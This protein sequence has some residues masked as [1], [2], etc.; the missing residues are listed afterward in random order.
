VPNPSQEVQAETDTLLSPQRG[1][2]HGRE[3]M[4]AHSRE[5]SSSRTRSS[6]GPLKH[7]QTHTGIIHSS[8]SASASSAPVHQLTRPI[9]PS[10]S[11][12]GILPSPG[13]VALSH[14]QSHSGIPPSL[15][16]APPRAQ[17]QFDPSSGS[18]VSST[19]THSLQ[20][21]SPVQNNPT[22]Q[23]L[24][25]TSSLGTHSTSHSQPRS[26][27]HSTTHS[28]APSLVPS[29]NHSRHNSRGHSPSHNPDLSPHD[30]PRPEPRPIST[31]DSQ[32]AGATVGLTFGFISPDDSGRPS[33]L[34]QRSE[35]VTQAPVAYHPE[36]SLPALPF[37]QQHYQSLLPSHHYIP[38]E[39]PR[40]GSTSAVPSTTSLPSQP[41]SLLVQTAYENDLRQGEWMYWNAMSPLQH[42]QPSSQPHQ[43]TDISSDQAQPSPP[44]PRKDG[45]EKKTKSQVVFGNVGLED[46]K[47]LSAP[48]TEPETAVSQKPKPFPVFSIG[49]TL[50][51]MRSD[52]RP[53]NEPKTKE[54]KERGR[55]NRIVD[56]EVPDMTDSHPGVSGGVWKFGSTDDVSSPEAT[57]GQARE[58]TQGPETVQ[59]N[60][61]NQTIVES[62][63]T[64]PIKDQLPAGQV[65][66]DF[67]PT[68]VQSSTI[69]TQYTHPEWLEV[70]DFG[71]R[72]GPGD[73]QRE[74]DRRAWD[75]RGEE[76]RLAREH[77][78]MD[79]EERDPDKDAR[80]RVSDRPVS[81]AQGGRPRRA[82]SSFVPGGGSFDRGGFNGRR[83]RGG[84]GYGRGHRY[85]R[86]SGFQSRQ[87]PFM[88]TPPTVFPP[89][90]DPGTTVFYPPP[91]PPPPMHY[92]ST[93]TNY[94]GYPQPPLPPQPQPPLPAPV[95][96]VQF[97]LDP[98][99]WQLLGQLEYYL[100]PQNMASDF[101][102][103]QRVSAFSALCPYVI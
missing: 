38:R 31:T 43:I 42:I 70:R 59:D 13:G 100:S 14:S 83:G 2:Q 45:Q 103:R 24:S 87:P 47:E 9:P 48:P 41:Y 53:S 89:L 95:S 56:R 57:R 69:A 85:G 63:A 98:V 16:N 91:P 20:S 25:A 52:A 64:E 19:S 67:S 71:H 50:G 94:E 21:G 39:P 22:S 55:S 8:S 80:E 3:D 36:T 76:D 88:V 10:S 72:F 37:P 73:S 74:Q 65:N 51:D 23:P 6:S 28:Q 4:G 81:H 97:P 49:L 92:M 15:A 1:P 66:G 18:Q 12:S 61:E 90:P 33:D 44:P 99:R 60:S 5:N 75:W 96:V 86:G 11:H 17:S 7:S 82:T 62:D 46:E 101:Y 54:K 29:K 84:S 27:N 77:P 35:S 93:L 58:T 34:R 30:S 78:E 68:T 26:R 79:R 40:L 102:L 32:E